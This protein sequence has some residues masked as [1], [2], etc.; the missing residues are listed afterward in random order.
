MFL[1]RLLI[2][3]GVEPVIMALFDFQRFYPYIQSPRITYTYA[4][5]PIILRLAKDNIVNSYNLSSLRMI[6]LGSALLTRELIL[7]LYDQ[8]GIPTKQAYGL[9]ETSPATHVQVDLNNYSCY[10]I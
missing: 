5:P 2:Y 1:V 8:L 10:V 9:S 7:A 3:I 4:A 6:T